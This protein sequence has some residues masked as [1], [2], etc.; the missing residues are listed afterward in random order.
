MENLGITAII[1]AISALFVTLASNAFIQGV[2]TKW[3]DRV[4]KKRESLD[5]IEVAEKDDDRQIRRKILD[6]LVEQVND[7]TVRF[8]QKELENLRLQSTIS[9][10][11]RQ[12]ESCQECHKEKANLLEKVTS[13]TARL[14]ILENGSK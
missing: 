2:V 14:D 4:N 1:G 9:D 8:T 6:S 10:M 12:I 7:L 11:K 3:L 13:L 5:S